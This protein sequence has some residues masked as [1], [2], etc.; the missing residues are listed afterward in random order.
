MK[1]RNDTYILAERNVIL[2]NKINPEMS[3]TFRQNLV[4]SKL[5]PNPGS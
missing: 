2:L 5:A 1:E 4:A 3:K